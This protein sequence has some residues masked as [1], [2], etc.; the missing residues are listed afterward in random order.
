MEVK[1]VCFVRHA[2]SS[3]DQPGLKDFDRPLDN[4]GLHDAPMMAR[5]MKELGLIPDYL[6][7]SGA[8]RAKSTA[9]YFRQEFDLSGDQF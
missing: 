7:S 2:K 8:N 6:I 5:K 4:R 1:D 9:E 3:W